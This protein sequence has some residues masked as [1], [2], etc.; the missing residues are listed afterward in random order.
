M[1]RVTGGLVRTLQ[2]ADGGP[3]TAFVDALLRAHSRTWGLVD[4]DIDTTSRTNIRDGGV[5][6]SVRRAC[7]ADPTG[8]LSSAPTAWQ[9]KGTDYTNVQVGELLE[10]RAVRHRLEAGD[11]FR[12][13]LADSLPDD[14]RRDWD[15]RLTNEAR[16]INGNAPEARVVTADDLAAWASRYPGL[17]L[18]FFPRGL[19]QVALHLESWSRNVLDATP[20]FVPVAGWASAR[21]NLSRHVALAESVDVAVMPLQGQAGVGKTRL[22][23]EVVSALPGANALVAYCQGD[24]AAV[25]VA[26]ELA[27][28]GEALGIIIADECSVDGQLRL[29]RTLTGHRRR[30]RAIAIDNSGERVMGLRPELLLGKMPRESL[31]Q[32]L[33]LNYANVPP[34]RRRAYAAL[35]EGFP[36][37][38]AD[39]CAYDGQIAAAGGI[40]P[41]VQGVDAYLRARLT[42][43]QLDS[44]AALSLVTRA[45][46]SGA[47]SVE[48]DALCVMLGLGR[49]ETERALYEIHDGPGFVN[50]TSRFMYVTPELVAQ[51]ATERAW[52]LWGRDAG[53]LFERVP[54]EL[55]GQFL[56]RVARSAP[57]E[58]RRACAAHFRQW[59][60]ELAPD[61]LTD[62]GVVE[63]LVRLVDTE[64]SEY[65]PRVRQLIE[66]ASPETL[67]AVRGDGLTGGGWG[68]R[69]ALVWLAERFA[70]FPEHFDDAERMLL[71]L[72]VAESEPQIGNNASAIWCQLYRI[73]LSGTAVAFG[74]RLNR[75][76]GYLLGPDE[77]AQDLAAIALDGI[78][79]FR[80]MR[81][82]G[83]TVVA[84]RLPPDDWRPRTAGEE[85]GAIG[86]AVSLL[87]E[88]VSFS[89]KLRPVAVR[90]ATQ[91][92]RSL[93][94]RGLLPALRAILSETSLT[95]EELAA[96]VEALDSTLAYDFGP[97]EG[98]PGPLAPAALKTAN[99][100]AG[101]RDTIA[102]RDLH[103]RIV[104]TV[105]KSQW[106][107][108]RVHEMVRARQETGT[109]AGAQISKDLDQLAAELAANPGLV[110]SELPWLTSDAAASAADL[111]VGLGQHDASGGLLP[112][113]LASA[114]TSPAPALA[115][116]YVHGLLASHPDLAGTVN[117]WIDDAEAR[118]P[119][120]AAELAISGGEPAR[121]FERVLRMFDE[122]R[123]PLAYL[124]D[125]NFVTG[126]RDELPIEQLLPLLERL[127]N[128]AESGDRLAERIGL[129]AI[130][131]RVPYETPAEQPPPLRDNPALREVAWRLL[132][133]R[134]AGS[135]PA[136]RW[137]TQL[138]VA[139]GRREPARAAHLARALV[140]G[141]D[142]GAREEGENAL[143]ALASTH[144]TEVME[145]LGQ[146]ML[147]ANTGWRFYVGTFTELFAAIP[148]EVVRTWLERAGVEGARRVAR[149]L[150][151]PTRD[152]Q[153]RA[154]VP[155][156][157][158]WV[159]QTFEDDE[160]TFREFCHGVH[161]MELYSGDIAAQ[162]EAEATLSREFLN[163]PL[164]RVREWAAL[165]ERSALDEAQR[166]RL[167]REEQDLP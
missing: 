151:P 158:A 30:I 93:V 144:P 10:G 66:R 150:P 9:Y 22:A 164:R 165:E 88:A 59:A 50:R 49:Q 38:A 46:Y 115:R 12:L 18:F 137:W 112:T 73:Y 31:N 107:A 143:G 157:T 61:A 95:D 100:L 27:N 126:R 136:T 129:E 109:Q 84:G 68:P 159:L 110:N 15:G 147:D 94:A 37:L 102:H 23:Y 156:L 74:E 62:V 139:L 163:H 69:R 72:A 60:S 55:L 153:G 116:G 48:L 86:S 28:D 19:G 85:R 42:A 124:A 70:Q 2:G 111:G 80:S 29:E 166:A 83:P 44:L 24:E 103:S 122:G 134:T 1:Y 71:R 118:A 39:L 57:E 11:A 92:L 140:G 45:G 121:A 26:I 6:T 125:H 35:A 161:N 54:Q 82:L 75:L 76:R 142:F 114:T 99:E 78:F 56:D 5:D 133:A 105:G 53:A 63:R 13:A 64:P 17:V 47:V 91:N 130:A 155:T 162:H 149:Q 90:I 98:Q 119:L 127:A 108:S 52:S 79:G 97:P 14:K 77:R 65:L 131:L 25:Q 7:A 96:L 128:A 87:R 67:A 120:V 36:R 167:D 141:D 146:A 152:A 81:M 132:E 33:D 148:A 160:R 16:K 40:A 43:A 41:A 113:I 8:W 20:Q 138:V 135:P 106:A 32:V 3:F 104:A 89:T 21:E 145:A 101:W 51:V 34:D 123:L 154:V 117:R 4:A 58:V